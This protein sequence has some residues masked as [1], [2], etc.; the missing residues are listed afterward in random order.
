MDGHIRNK[1]YLDVLRIILDY[2]DKSKLR[3]GYL[4][5]LNSKESTEPVV[6]HSKYQ[7]KWIEP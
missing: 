5:A 1:L 4:K 6:I 7:L 3:R 2:Q